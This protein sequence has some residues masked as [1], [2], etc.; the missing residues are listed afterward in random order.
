M[1]INLI[2]DTSEK[3]ISILYDGYNII[4]NTFYYENDFEK[5]YNV[6]IDIVKNENDFENF[7]NYL[8]LK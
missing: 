3:T 8:K 2:L 5:M 6:L 1:K 7:E 4:K